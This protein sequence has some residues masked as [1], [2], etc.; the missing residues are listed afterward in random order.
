MTTARSP[1]AGID[2]PPGVSEIAFLAQLDVRADPSDRAAL[3]RI[4]DVLGVA[5]PLEANT[6]TTSTDGWRRAA[7]LGPDEWLAIGPPGSLDEAK[8]ADIAGLSV[9]DVSAGRATISLAGPHARAT[10]E[11]GCSIDLDPRRFG[12]GQCAQTI[13]AR[14][15]V[16]LIAVSPEPEYWILVRP[17][18]AAYVAAWIAD[19]IE[20]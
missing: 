8:L 11:L 7:W 18:F 2:L 9:V 15:N 17:S 5:L 1:L 14:A 3:D 19:A 13:V 20:G 12:P 10:L 6:V 4:G 16:V